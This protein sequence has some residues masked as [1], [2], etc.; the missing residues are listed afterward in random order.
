MRDPGNEVDPKDPSDRTTQKGSDTW[1]V[2]SFDQSNGY[3]WIVSLVF[4]LP[5]CYH[6]GSI[7]SCPFVNTGT[8]RTQTDVPASHMGQRK[9]TTRQLHLIGSP[10][11]A[12]QLSPVLRVVFSS[13]K[14]LSSGSEFWSS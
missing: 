7:L 4:L 14:A 2:F 1:Q 10:R 5:H 6:Q 11:L 8:N 13:G 3:T 12:N 9:V